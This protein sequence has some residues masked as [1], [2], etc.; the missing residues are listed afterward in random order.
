[1]AKNKKIVVLGAGYA[2]VLVAK[3]IE[4][5]LRK[6]KKL[7]HVDITIIDKNPFHTMLTEL[8]EVAA[9]RVDEENIRL[10]IKK[11][12]AGR[13]VNVVQDNIV[14][15]DYKNN[16][17]IGEGGNYEYDHLVMSS[18]CKT[19]FW[20]VKGAEEYS[21]PLWSFQEAVTLRDH[22]MKMFREASIEKDINRKKELLTFF[23]VGAGFTGVEMVGELAELAPILCKRFHIDPELV[24]INI[25]DMLPGPMPFLHKKAIDRA[26]KRLDK[27]NV[28]QIYNASVKEV[29]E[30]GLEFE[31]A[32]K[33]N[34]VKSETI[35]WVAGTEGSDIAMQSEDLGIV[36]KSRGRIQ[37]DKHLRSVQY[38]NVYVAGDNMF[39]IPEGEER[40]VPQMVENCEHCAP[41]IAKNIIAEAF[42]GE[43]TEEYKPA[44]KGAMVCIG[45]RYGTA[46]GGLPGKFMVFPS[47]I[48]MFAKHFINILYFVQ[49]LGWNKVFKYIKAQFFT[50]RDDRSFVGGHF[51]NRTPVFW[52]VPL[53]M[54]AGVYLLYLAYRRTQLGWI[55]GPLLH[56]VFY[57]IAASFRP[58]APGSLTDIGLFD[59]ARLTIHIVN[60]SMLAWFRFVPVDLFLQ[61]F[62]VNSHNSQ[63]FW[64]WSII[65]FE[66]LIGL[67]LIVGLFTKLAALG[68]IA[69]AVIALSTVGLSIHQFW[70]PFAAIAFF[71]AGRVFSLD[72]YVGPWLAKK[73]KK[74]PFVQKWYLYN[75]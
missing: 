44:F 26:I 24:N 67:A 33:T 54:M 50:I 38:P 8:H 62:V 25:I 36:E 61:N 56:D 58:I 29:K 72:Y 22:I 15:T 30:K 9:W 31:V 23:V 75:D 66:A 13:K 47:F 57:D 17:L 12:F 1:M 21:F 28:N 63:M 60:E 41:I 2:G 16:T 35:I 52:T 55:D 27:M 49:V 53:R 7:D 14:E 74:I 46:Y 51:S 5:K 69:W 19:T 18:G 42:G 10:D 48:A 4:K 34:Y 71:T 6:A 73:W 68:L 11:I 37:T 32:G 59:Y 70:M 45:G 43:P 20:G 39:F 64:Q 65:I 3:K 40:P